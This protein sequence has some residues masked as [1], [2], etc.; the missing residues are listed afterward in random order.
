VPG[1]P[2]SD[3]SL[4]SGLLRVSAVRFER[5]ETGVLRRARIGPTVYRNRRRASGRGGLRQAAALAILGAM[6]ELQE[7]ARKAGE[8][9]LAA[10][11]S[12]A[13]AESCTGGWV[14]KTVTDIEGSSQWFDRGFVTYT[15]DS[16]RQMLGVSA[17]TLDL[18]GAVS[19]ATV[20]EMAEGAL[21]HSAAGVSVAVSGVAGPGGGT[22]EKPVGLVWLAWARAGGERRTHRALF[23][24]D[25]D[26]VRRQSVAA[27]LEGV[28]AI[29]G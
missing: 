7:L 14:A 3:R 13:T 11:L 19:E 26:A 9:L 15:N 8:R 4:S 12:L 1:G 22:A 18:Q 27:A 20:R 10:G 2:L 5:S 21:R 25:R 16:K 17:E 6:D 23:D 28:L 29:I 24:G